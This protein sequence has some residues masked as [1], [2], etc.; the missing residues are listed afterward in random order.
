M[1]KS[2]IHKTTLLRIRRN[3]PK[4]SSKIQ[5]IPNPMLME[6]HLPDFAVILHPHL[7]RKPAF[8]ALGTTLDGLV[9][10]R[11]KQSMKMLRHD[12]EA[13]QVIPPLIPIV[14]QSLD[15]QLSICR[16]NEE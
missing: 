16:S 4:L 1:H 15:Q 9:W 13:M 10:S 2:P 5:S 14:K 12:Y 6:S 3:I 8:D 11:G 7:M